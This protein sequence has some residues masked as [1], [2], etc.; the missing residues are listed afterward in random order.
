M[1]TLKEKLDPKSKK[2][3]LFK[4][5]V[6]MGNSKQ[7]TTSIFYTKPLSNGT[8][9]FILILAIILVVFIMSYF[10]GKKIWK[11]AYHNILKVYHSIFPKDKDEENEE[12]EEN[13][14][15]APAIEQLKNKMI[16]ENYEGLSNKEPLQDNKYCFI[17]EQK[18]YRSCISVNETD[19][20]MSGDIFPSNQICINPNL[21][22]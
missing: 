8:Y 19:K 4:E 15:K 17:G 10:F 6:N 1:A 16:K 11:K 21:R 2:D 18:G 7:N 14:E 20:C 13:E 9:I 22:V 5:L 12:N 3:A